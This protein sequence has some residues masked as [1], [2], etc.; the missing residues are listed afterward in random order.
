MGLGSSES[1]SCSCRKREKKTRR[2]QASKFKGICGC[3]LGLYGEMW[4]G[5]AFRV[6]INVEV[7]SPS[8]SCSTLYTPLNCS[9]QAPALGV[10]NAELRIW[11]CDWAIREVSEQPHEFQPLRLSASSAKTGHVYYPKPQILSTEP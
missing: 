10:V 11:I 2:A 7:L 8:D 6:N 4:K 1:F 5:I 9:E 3:G